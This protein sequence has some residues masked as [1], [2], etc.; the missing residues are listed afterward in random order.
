[1]AFT[2][3]QC[4]REPNKVRHRSDAEITFN[5]ESGLAAGKLNF[6]QRELDVRLCKR[7]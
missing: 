5:L 3:A 1:M 7:S 4:N 6:F 2:I